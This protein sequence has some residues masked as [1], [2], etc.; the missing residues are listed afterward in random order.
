MLALILWIIITYLLCD[1]YHDNIFIQ[2]LLEII[3]IY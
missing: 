2:I 1:N 3:L